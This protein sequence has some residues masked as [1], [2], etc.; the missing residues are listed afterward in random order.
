MLRVRSLFS[1]VKVSIE[2]IKKLRQETSSPI[3]ECKKALEESAG[4][5]EAA[6]KWLKAKGMVTAEKKADKDTREG[7]VAARTNDH[8]S[9]AVL[10]E[11][12]CE[13][14]FVAKN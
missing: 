4:D 13:T 6:L 10:L 5:H 12:N 1:T 8:R 3:G 9:A 14:D 11:V 2:A 7:I